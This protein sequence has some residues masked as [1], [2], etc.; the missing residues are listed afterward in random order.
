MQAAATKQL[1]RTMHYGLV[2]L[3]PEVPTKMQQLCIRASEMASRDA[4]LQV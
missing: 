2:L 3:V 4:Q 1:A